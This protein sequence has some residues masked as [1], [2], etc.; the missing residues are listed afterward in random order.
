MSNREDRLERALRKT[1]EDYEILLE[2]VDLPPGNFRR[3]YQ[4][5]WEE[6]LKLIKER[7]E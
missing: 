4:A 2:C 6:Y 1:L 3:N 5:H 7:L